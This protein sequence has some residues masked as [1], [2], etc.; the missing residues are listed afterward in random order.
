MEG[1]EYENQPVRRTDVIR[2]EDRMDEEE[3]PEAG[4][5][6]GF[7][8]VIVTCWMA[9]SVVRS[10]PLLVNSFFIGSILLFALI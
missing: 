6:A 9:T 8:A 4:Q 7:V 5:F 10:K 3:L 2:E 1:G